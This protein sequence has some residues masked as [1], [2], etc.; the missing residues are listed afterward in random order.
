LKTLH[1]LRHAKTIEGPLH[2]TD[3][4]R[5]LTPRGVKAAKLLGEHLTATGISVDRV[6]CSTARRARETYELIA[7]T[8]KGATVA[9]RD[10]LYLVEAS[11]LLEF[12]HGLPDKADSIMI[13]GH[14]PGL[15]HIAVNLSKTA[16]RGKAEALTALREK[17]PTGTLCT[18]QFDL[19]HWRDVNAA[20][21][22]LTAFVRPKDLEG[23]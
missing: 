14:N 8:L 16:T 23:E 12:I 19:A 7:P 1:L 11:D 10:R 2:G 18:L 17:F 3:H 4:A 20:T 13:V 22:T 5:F 15:H 21:G 9:F 6:F